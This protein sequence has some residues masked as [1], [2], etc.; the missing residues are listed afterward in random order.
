MASN[1]A[2]LDQ[3]DRANELIREALAIADAVAESDPGNLEHTTLTTFGSMLRENLR[4][5]H[6]ITRCLHTPKRKELRK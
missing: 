3:L 4:E 5:L 1:H 6:R 2:Q